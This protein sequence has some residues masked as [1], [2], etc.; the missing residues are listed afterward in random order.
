LL[1]CVDPAYMHARTP[2]LPALICHTDGFEPAAGVLRSDE[3]RIRIGGC[4][5]LS[6]VGVGRH[7]MEAR[8]FVWVDGV[9]EKV[10]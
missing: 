1:L 3:R 7:V 2:S 4:S 5:S 10:A 9:E 6:P 8:F